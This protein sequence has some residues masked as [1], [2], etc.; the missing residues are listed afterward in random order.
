MKE[1][2]CLWAAQGNKNT[3]VPVPGTGRYSHPPGPPLW[4]ATAGWKGIPPSGAKAAGASVP[5]P[6]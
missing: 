2:P 5:D 6:R 1:A 4:W 3:L